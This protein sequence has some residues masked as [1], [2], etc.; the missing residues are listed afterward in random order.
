MLIVE[1][2]IIE[3]PI[4]ELV[5]KLK[6]EL[7][8][9]GIDKL[10]SIIKKP[11]N[12]Q[13]TC[14]IHK[15]GQESRPSCEIL[16]EDK[17]GVNA[18]TCHCF[19]C[20]YSASFPRFVADCLGINKEE[21][22]D[23]LLSV[24]QYSVQGKSRE[25]ELLSLEDLISP[26]TEE[27]I[28]ALD[29]DPVELDN[30]RYVHPYMF[31]RK[32]TEEVIE[33]FEVGYDPKL[34][35][36]TFPVYVNGKCQFVCKRRVKFKRFDMPRIN[37][38]PIYGLD[39]LTSNE[40]IVCE[41]IINA[42]TCWSYGKQAVALFGTGSEYQIEQLKHIKQR[43]IILALDGDEAGRKGTKKI[44]KALKYNKVL[45]VFPIPEGKDINDLSKEEFNSLYLK[46]NSISV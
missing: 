42:L 9:R 17:P 34:D 39:Y 31:Q 2:K 23:W 41:S 10:H 25:V 46:C 37:P 45:S 27:N 20:S 21:A 33:K 36:I 1:D 12:I 6:Q 26:K 28:S 29:F 18:G 32:L 13:I 24:S 4:E 5:D 15:N 11:G 38:K 19:T 44:L 43:N 3:T 7:I 22:N 35:A 40:V 8:L 16:T 14:P 30:Y